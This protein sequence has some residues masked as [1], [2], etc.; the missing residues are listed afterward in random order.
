MT[1]RLFCPLLST[2]ALAAWLFFPA[3]ARAHCDGMDGPVVKA[4]QR[5]LQASD[6]NLWA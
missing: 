4:A 3:V 6:V 5:A 1:I 2:Y